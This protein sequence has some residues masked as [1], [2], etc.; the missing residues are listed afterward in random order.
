MT[1][2]S[3]AAGRTRPLSIIVVEDDQFLLEVLTR[4]LNHERDRYQVVSPVTNIPAAV[5][6]CRKYSPDL[7]LVDINLPGESGI[8]AIPKFRQLCPRLRIILCTAEVTDARILEALR[9]G[10]DGFVEKTGT[11]D[12]FIQ[13]IERV[14]AGEHYLCPRST[15]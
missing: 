15:A 4:L 6:A 9:T 12:D 8:Q 11:W 3:R 1:E 10:V 5:E 2:L 13:A 7:L 14:A